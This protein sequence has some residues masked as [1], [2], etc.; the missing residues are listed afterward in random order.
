[1]RTPILQFGTSRFLQAHAD[2]FISEAMA[3]G[4]DVGPITVV[5]SSGDVSRA[6]RLDGLAHPFPVQIEGLING[7]HSST[8]TYVNSIKRTLSTAGDW[9]KVIDVFVNEAEIVLSNTGDAGFL[10]RPSD[11]NPVFDQSMSYPAK[12]MLLLRQR[13]EQGAKPIQIMP[14]ELITNNG[15][16]LKARVLELANGAKADFVDYLNTDVHW[17]NSLVDRIVSQP[18]EPAGAVAEPYALWAIQD[19]ANLRAPCRH[20]AIQIVPSLETI[21]SLKLFVLNLGHSFLADRWM[22]T[23]GVPDLLMRDVMNMSSEKTAL[24][25]MLK[26]E[27]A[28]AFGA[29]GLADE[30]TPYLATTLDRFANPFLEHRISDIAQN[31]SQKVERRM[32]ALLKWA[33]SKGDFSEKPTLSRIVNR[34]Q[35]A[36]S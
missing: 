19:H 32:G 16:T 23:N 12:L 21:A 15:D 4:Q 31:H 27:V 28:P 24:I 34:Q 30:F 7:E 33:A 6:Q 17:I 10:A 1:M 8:L 13:F 26:S 9:Q 22:Q 36:T 35:K 29:A 14:M 25:Q 5:Q 20:P 3:E 11:E 2:L 18:L